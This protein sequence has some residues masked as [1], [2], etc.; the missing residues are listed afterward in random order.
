MNII[1]KRLIK[2]ASVE[3]VKQFMESKGYKLDG[4][5]YKQTF[6]GNIFT[7]YVTEVSEAL[8]NNDMKFTMNVDIQ[9]ASDAN[10]EIDNK[11]KSVIMHINHAIDMR[12]NKIYNKMVEE[13]TFNNMQD[14]I[15]HVKEI[16]NDN[17]DIDYA[18]DDII[19]CMKDKKML[20][21]ETIDSCKND[22]FYAN[23][24]I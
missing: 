10:E 20:K 6:T 11:D 15:D 13:E 2:K 7:P 8:K 9:N 18:K 5:H 16:I 1:S 12:V 21:E 19:K 22:K 24:N 14:A 3:E 23:V 4:K 17:I